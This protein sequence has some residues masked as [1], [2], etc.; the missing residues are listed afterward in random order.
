MVHPQAW[1]RQCL[2][3]VALLFAKA[4]LLRLSSRLR[5]NSE[6][7]STRLIRNI[8]PGG[9]LAGQDVPAFRDDSLLF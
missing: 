6:R 4:R 7:F 2:L 9:F 8:L 1:S 3:E 5:V